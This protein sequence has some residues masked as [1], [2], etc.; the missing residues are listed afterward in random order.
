[1]KTDP[2]TGHQSAGAGTRLRLNSDGTARIDIQATE[3]RPK[4]ET[5]H[6]NDSN[7]PQQ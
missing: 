1:V 2:N 4:R 6:F 5:V 3:F 7:K